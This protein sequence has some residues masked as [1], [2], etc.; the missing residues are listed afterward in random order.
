MSEDE[1]LELV[2]SIS[3]AHAVIREAAL[4]LRRELSP[5]APAAKAAFKAEEGAFRLK[6]ELQRLDIENPES[7]PRREVLPEVRQGDTVIE[8]ARLRRGRLGGE[9]T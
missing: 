5:K 1:R 4:R 9:E 7:A 6:R 2:G 3:E 8:G